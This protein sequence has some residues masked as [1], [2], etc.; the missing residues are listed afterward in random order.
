MKRHGVNAER[1]QQASGYRTIGARAVDPERPAIDQLDFPTEFELV[2]LGVPA[3]IVVVL[4]DQVRASEPAV[5][6]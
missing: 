5:A 2:P 6:R 3:E 4:K 1:R